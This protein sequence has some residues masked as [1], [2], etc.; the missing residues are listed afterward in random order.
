[1]SST[2]SRILLRRI[3]QNVR[4]SI[5]LG[6]VSETRD[7]HSSPV[8]LKKQR[9]RRQYVD[10][11]VV[12]HVKSTKKTM[13]LYDDINIMELS[14]ALEQD[15]NVVSDSLVEI[16]ESN[17]K[18]LDGNTPLDRK[19]ILDLCSVFNVKPK[20]VTRPNEERI[21]KE[22]SEEKDVFPQPPPSPSE[23]VRR[24]P[25]V[26]I[27][28]H[29]DHGKT[30]LLD[31]LR[32][33]S[34]VQS[35]FGG[36]TQ[37]IGAFSVQLPGT[38]NKVTFL[39]TP[40]HAA[41]KAMRERGARATDIV[42]LVVAADDGVNEQTVESI[43]YAREA[44]VPIVV[45]INKIDKPQADPQKTRR[46]LLQHDIVVEDMGG[47]VQAVEISALQGT[48]IKALQEALILQAELM[49]LK[50][51]PKG[52]SEGI[53][54][55]ATSAQGLGK[56]CTMI[57]QR[58]TVK[59]GTVLVA[60]TAWGKVRSMTD[61]N[62]KPLKEATPSTPVR[63][64]GWREIL[65]SPGEKILEVENEQKAQEVVEFRKRKEMDKRAEIEK[66]IIDERRM[67]E[68]D[69]YLKNRQ[70]L[71]DKG[72]RYGS[73]YKL[74]VKKE[75]KSQGKVEKEEK[76]ILR[77][78]LRSDVDGT[79]EALLNVIDTY[80]SDQCELQIVDFGV[81]SPIENHI[82]L[83][84]ET[85]SIIYCFNTSIPA[86]IRVL[87]GEKNVKVEQ[88][89]VIYRLIDSLKEKLSEKIPPK[90]EL[91]QVGEGHVLKEFMIPGKTKK[92]VP[93]AGCL[94]DWGVFSKTAIYRFIRGNEVVYEG[95]V[96][97]LK[98]ENEFVSTAKTNTE[99]GLA[100]EDKDVRFK[101]DDTIE[102]FEEEVIPQKIDW[103]PAGF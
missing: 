15:L 66:E 56:V 41:F 50:S 12:K 77:I 82:E 60:G 78:I 7:F 70:K 85:D 79:L 37:H 59:R 88:Y 73:T 4:A 3:S 90:I 64:S 14:K 38:K 26:T 10:P 36:I 28:G 80:S 2:L 62:N 8:F 69:K 24:A 61:E 49:D 55:E 101:D 11:V 93:I 81:G 9:T 32:N 44:G 5:S 74:I 42:V 84:E 87:A 29:V 21:L 47:D 100:L 46:D 102:V 22:L 76:P 99:V 63:M 35:E 86:N 92:R 97:S 43:K 103:Y 67:E 18:F 52:L 72:I 71:L 39:D 23:C 89:N 57:V 96:E 1:M 6:W 20:F 98:C 16:D 94:V 75:E 54:I 45:A 95:R 83:A 51:T 13:E 58:G 27:M 34:I 33:S 31:S 48:N 17:M 68:R 19:Q 91:K 40:G 25:V 65:P 30:T 53:V